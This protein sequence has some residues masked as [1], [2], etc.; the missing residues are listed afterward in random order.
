MKQEGPVHDI[1]YRSHPALIPYEANTALEQCIRRGVS[2]EYQTSIYQYKHIWNSVGIS[3]HLCSQ[4]M[5]SA[6]N[7]QIGKA[8]RAIREV[9]RL[10]CKRIT[11]RIN[12]TI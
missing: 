10:N 7:W 11:K 2:S 6:W 3:Y 9:E 5:N 12:C 8:A 1:Q 4:K